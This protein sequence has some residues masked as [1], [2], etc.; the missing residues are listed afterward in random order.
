MYSVGNFN[1]RFDKVKPSE[2]R[3]E[4]MG[5]IKWILVFITAM[6]FISSPCYADQ[7]A[8]TYGG[9]D[10]E[11]AHSI[12][13]TADNGYVVAGRTASFGVGNDKRDSWVLKL[14]PDGTIAWQKT[15]GMTYHE[16]A[17]SIQQTADNGYVVA[18]ATA[19]IYGV[20][21]DDA[22]ILKLN[23]DGTIA[24]QKTYGGIN[25][26]AAWSIH[27]T[28]DYGYIVLGWT[29]SFGGGDYDFWVLKLDSNGGVEWEMAYGG[30][31]N[32]YCR[33]IRRAKDGGYIVAGQTNSFGAGNG[34][35]WVLKLNSNG[36]V[37]WEKAYGGSGKENASFIRQTSDEGFIVT[38]YTDSFGAGNGDIWVLKL[39]SD[40]TVAWQKTYG[41]S[42]TDSASSIQQA[43]NGGYVVAGRTDSFGKGY[44]DIWVLKLN[45]DGTVAWQKTYGGSG[46]EHAA[47]VGQTFDDGYVVTGYTNSS[48]A[49][50]RDLW[51]L[52]LDNNGEISGCD[53]MGISEATVS[54]TSVQ[55]QDSNAGV[56]NSSATVSDTTVSGQDSEAE[57]SIIC[58]NVAENQPPTVADAG[59]DQFLQCTNPDATLVVLDGSGSS[60]PDDD[61][62]TYTWTGPFP[63]G[64]GTVMGVNPTVSLPL[65]EHT[66]SLVV[67]DG[68]VDSE[69]DEVSIA[70]TVGIEGL[71]PPLVDLVPEGEEVLFPD[72]AFKCGRTLPLK[73]QLYCGGIPLSDADVSQPEIVGLVSLHPGRLIM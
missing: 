47:S 6:L 5:K 58:F 63:E 32:D 55:G 48:G 59:S 68:Q 11:E 42:G 12:Q 27:Q 72:K 1:A 17:L 61:P 64:G 7:W 18:G 20:G 53:A 49:G 21:K 66:V 65:G 30:G 29:T 28:S 46:D 13:Q 52:K 8:I 56:D 60:D 67:N 25:D 33:S 3:R 2:E 45:S 26:D 34:D 62:L 36:G 4:V 16:C 73:L 43:K 50:G 23:P 38:G 19:T 15:Y 54:D 40:G 70:I 31:G 57:T 69:P 22:W 51:V 44:R 39:N 10:D 24:W 14:D 41:G 9:S 35:F 37:E 71:Q